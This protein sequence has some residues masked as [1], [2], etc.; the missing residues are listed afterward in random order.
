MTSV[1]RER[2]SWH[3]VIKRETYLVCFARAPC[4]WTDRGIHSFQQL[5]SNQNW[6]G[7]AEEL[8]RVAVEQTKSTYMRLLEFRQSR[9]ESFLNI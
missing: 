2:D 8:R 3:S 4:E 7:R 1:S 6:L 5:S 9:E